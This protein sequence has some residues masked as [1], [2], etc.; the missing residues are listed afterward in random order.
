MT[1]PVC[2]ADG[3]GGSLREG[4]SGT[5]SGGAGQEDMASALA[6]ISWRPGHAHSSWGELDQGWY[7][8][9]LYI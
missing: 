7:I 8:A 3:A 4:G 5:T 1:S 9:Y 2:S 6:L